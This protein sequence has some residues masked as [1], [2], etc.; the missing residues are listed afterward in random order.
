MSNSRRAASTWG[1]AGFAVAILACGGSDVPAGG[2]ATEAGAAAP[3]PTPVEVAAVERGSIAREITVSGVVRPIRSIGVNSQL[4]GALRS[5]LV[6][7][8]DVV[9]AGRTLARLDDRELRAQLGAAEA[10]LEVAEAALARAESLREQQVITLAEYERD[11]MALAAARAQHDQLLTRAGFATVR[12]PLTGVITDKLVEAGDVVAPQTR[13]F[14]LADVST[15]VV[16]VGV[17]E[18]DVVDLAVG[19][20]VGVALDAYPGRSLAGVIRRVFPTANPATRLVPVEVALQGAQ[21]AEA[22]P[23]FLARVTFGLGTRGGVLLVPASAI[24]GGGEAGPEAVFVVEAST[25]S[26]RPVSTGM[27]SRGRVE[28]LDGLEA[29]ELV[30]TVGNNALRDGAEVRIVSS[31]ELQA[32]DVAAP[33]GREGGLRGPE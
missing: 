19:D 27:T 23:G 32:P 4:S 25:A 22:R 6:E 26:R 21:T 14:E 15:L 8:G 18:L 7:E 9:R 11:R 33:M 3:P 24:V 16:R 2:N 12:A 17:S 28:I 20:T 13:L 10:S 31:S 5:V 30:V 1:A 29:E